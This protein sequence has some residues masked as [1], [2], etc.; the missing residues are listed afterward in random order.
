MK[1]AVASSKMS[2][3]FIFLLKSKSKVSSVR[4]G[5]AEAG[6][7]DAA[8][9][10]PVLAARQLVAGRAR[11]RDRAAPVV[12]VWAWRS[13]VSRTV[14]HAGEAELAEG[15][16]EFDEVHVRVSCRAIDE[17]AVEGELADERIDLA[18]RE[19]HGRPALEVAADEAIGR[20]RRARG[21]PRGVVDDGGA[22]LLGAARARRG[23]GGRRPRRRGGGCASQTRA[24][25]RPAR[26]ARPEQRAASSAACVAGDRRRAMR[27]QP[28]RRCA[29]ARAAAARCC[30]SSRRTWRS[31]HCTCDAAADPAGRRAVVGA[32]R[33]RRS[34]RDARCARR[35]GSSETARPAAARARAAPRQTSPRPGAWWCRGC[36]CRP[37]APP[38]D[39]DRPAPPRASRSAG[40]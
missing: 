6:L 25:V 15:A 40:P 18:Q 36:A 31:S 23:C 3:R 24:D 28:A 16:V 34:H 10:E 9:E 12:S 20:R 35:S 5:V 7:L 13:R 2:A 26:V 37:S 11:R 4:V 33:P 19:R 8:L 30:G 38:S 29:R 21:R 17:I 27:C 22:V 32:P 14:G 1:R 39:R